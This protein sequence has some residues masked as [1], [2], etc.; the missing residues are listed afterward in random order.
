MGV[1]DPKGV[2][3]EKQN[4]N[5]FNAMLKFP[6]PFIFTVVGKTKG[7]EALADAFADNV[8]QVIDSISGECMDIQVTPR[9]KSFTR[10]SVKAKVEN[11]DMINGI[12]EA[13]D[14]IDMAVMRY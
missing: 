8:K 11:A 3:D 14:N 1:F 5:I 12:Y 6:V 4:G 10:V 2:D 7:E 13:V 9:G